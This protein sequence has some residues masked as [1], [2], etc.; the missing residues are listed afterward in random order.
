MNRLKYHQRKQEQTYEDMAGR[1]GSFLSG[2]LKEHYRSQMA[3]QGIRNVRG[4]FEMLSYKCPTR[5]ATSGDIQH[6]NR[7]SKNTLLT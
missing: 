1:F 3:L 5:P 6:V 4:A 2:M 7:A